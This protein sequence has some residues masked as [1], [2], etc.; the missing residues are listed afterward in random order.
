MVTTSSALTA[1]APPSAMAL[2][3]ET[4]CCSDRSGPSTKALAS[5]VDADE[6]DGVE[7]ASIGAGLT[8]SDGVNDSGAGNVAGVAADAL[9]APEV[10]GVPL[11]AAHSS[12]FWL[13]E[14]RIAISRLAT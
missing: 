8:S 6:I 7:A 9:G 5:D 13:R 12:R 1:M 4:R 10:V 11:P 3:P 2:R 14:A